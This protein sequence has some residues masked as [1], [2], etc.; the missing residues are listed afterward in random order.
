VVVVFCYFKQVPFGTWVSEIIG[1]FLAQGAQ[2]PRLLGNYFR[3]RRGCA[4]RPFFEDWAHWCARDG[5]VKY[6]PQGWCSTVRTQ[7]DVVEP[8]VRRIQ[9]APDS[10]WVRHLFFDFCPT[11][12]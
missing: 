5:A 11:F 10:S 3:Y 6:I 4:P 12:S 2:D 7:S 9:P 1:H 8:G